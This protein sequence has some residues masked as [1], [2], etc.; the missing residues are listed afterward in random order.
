MSVLVLGI[1]NI[2]LGD[3]GIGVRVVE[4][5][6]ARYD[7]PDAVQVV[8]GGTA[9]MGLL[10]LIAGRDHVIIVDAVKTGAEPGTIVRLEGDAI[11]VGFR[12][13]ISPH[14]LG[15][16]DV[17]AVLTML[18]QAPEELVVIGIEPAD[19][20]FGVGLSPQIEAQLD[21]L[22]DA[23]I[24]ELSRLGQRPKS[25]AVTAATTGESDSAVGG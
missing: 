17:L 1:G 5:L 2:L 9:G 19:L 13:R 12:Q 23:V 25:I 11:P 6:E 10:D 18:D 8:D 3:E 22:V 14:S 24:G 15:L 4:A 16:G 20:D 21:P 7:L